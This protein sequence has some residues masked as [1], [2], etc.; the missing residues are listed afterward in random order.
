MLTLKDFENDYDSI[1]DDEKDSSSHDKNKDSSKK[2]GKPGKEN[3]V[4][5][6]DV[7]GSGKKKK[8]EPDPQEMKAEAKRNEMPD[9]ILPLPCPKCKKKSL[10]FDK[11]VPT[12]IR[13]G[14]VVALACV[15]AVNLEK[16]L[17]SIHFRC[18]N[19]KCKSNW[20]TG[21]YFLL[22]PTGVLEEK[23]PGIWHV[24]K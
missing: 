6:E 11:Y 1:G 8:K 22:K 10:F 12:G 24:P 16:A 13:V 2:G 19:K 21:K 23:R 17:S 3:D 7:S 4:K 18:M 14:I 9:M 15:G 5:A 20:K